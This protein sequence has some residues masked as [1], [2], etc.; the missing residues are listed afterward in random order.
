MQG[1]QN[2]GFIENLAHFASYFKDHIDCAVAYEPNAND[3]VE[4]LDN[5]FYK[6]QGKWIKPLRW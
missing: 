5:F 6:L 4:G 3:K 1:L 2:S